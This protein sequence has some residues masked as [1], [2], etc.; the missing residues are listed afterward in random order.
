MAADLDLPGLDRSLDYPVLE[1]S[2]EKFGKNR[3]YIESHLEVQ[4]KCLLLA[5]VLLTSLRALGFHPFFKFFN[6]QWSL[7][8]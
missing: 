8:G 4:P 6:R 1:D 7:Y 5:G 3:D 2:G